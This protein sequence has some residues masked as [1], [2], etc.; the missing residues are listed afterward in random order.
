[1]RRR[2]PFARP[3]STARRGAHVRCAPRSRWP[4]AGPPTRRSPRPGSQRPAGER[5][6]QA[7]RRR[8]ATSPTRPIPEPPHPRTAGSGRPPR[9]V[10]LG[11]RSGH[12]QCQGAASA[13]SSPPRAWDPAARRPGSS[14]AMRSGSRPAAPQRP[15]ARRTPQ[16]L[17][18]QFSPRPPEGLSQ[19]PTRWSSVMPEATLNALRGDDPPLTVSRRRERWLST[20]P[21]PEPRPLGRSVDPAWDLLTRRRRGPP[22]CLLRP[23]AAD[24]HRAPLARP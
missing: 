5:T 17:A 14:P 8:R 18:G 15:P 16:P 10:G 20:D 13:P 21:I 11:T 24:A 23:V 4:L 22:T 7:R 6:R 1:M 19:D 12:G 9:R 2:A 3:S